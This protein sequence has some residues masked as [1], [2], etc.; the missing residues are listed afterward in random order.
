MTTTAGAGPSLTC[1]KCKS[2]TMESTKVRRFSSGLVFIGFTLWVPCL[3][4][5]LVATGS[6]MFMGGAGTVAM[7][8]TMKKSKQEAV[9]SL[10]KIDGLP[11]S[12]IAEFDQ[13]GTIEQSVLNALPAD[14]RAR[15]D[16]I[17]SLYS[18]SLVGAGL[19][20]AAATGIG[21]C[22]VMLVYF[23]CVPGFIV[24]LVLT[25]KKKV[26]RCHTCGYIFERS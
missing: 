23:F 1:E 11:A 9:A 22:G 26:W 6:A 25:L 16:S 3:L 20:G 12:I 7:T 13:H 18:A 21:G 8:E 19:G 17:T 10:Q 5:L 2:G 24:G 14:K 4:I 15:V